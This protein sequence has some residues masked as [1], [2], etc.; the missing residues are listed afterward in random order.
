MLFG[1]AK[2]CSMSSEFIAS[3]FVLAVRNLRI[4][5]DFYMNVLGFKRDFGDE[6]DGWSFLSRNSIR[7]MLGECVD[8]V[9]ASELNNHSYFAYMN[10]T[11]VDDLFHEIVANGGVPTSH[12]TNKPWGIREFGITTPDG[13]RIM[14]GETLNTQ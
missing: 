3:R 5:T 2:L 14:F 9:P 6:S 12:P 4:S 7:L 10:V 1:S 8:E 13:H 11:S